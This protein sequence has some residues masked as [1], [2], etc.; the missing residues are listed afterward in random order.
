[1]RSASNPNPS[2]FAGVSCNP[3]EVATGGG[4]DAF[5]SDTIS[6]SL[7]VS[8]GGNPTGWQIDDSTGA[9]ARNIVYVICASP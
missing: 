8:S 7:P 2:N 4:G 1:M 6:A 9:K 3:G 5:G